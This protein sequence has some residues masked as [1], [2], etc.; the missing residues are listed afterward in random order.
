MYLCSPIFRYVPEVRLLILLC[1]ANMLDED[2]NDLLLAD[3]SVFDFILFILERAWK[4]PSHR[5]DGF[6][7]E[8]V[9]DGMTGLAK[10]DSNKTLLVKKG[11]LPRLMNVLRDS[12]SDEEIEK[13]VKCVWELAFD[14]ENRKNFNVCIILVVNGELKTCNRCVSALNTFGRETRL[15]GPYFWVI[16][17]SLV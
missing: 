3:D 5:F 7:V 4:Y 2:Q 1:L 13:A 12:S 10:N 15:H 16:N 9:I 6:S 14:E 11:V 8:E 17:S